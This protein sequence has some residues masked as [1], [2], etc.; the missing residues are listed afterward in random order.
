MNKQMGINQVKEK[1]DCTGYEISNLNCK[2][3]FSRSVSNYEESSLVAEEG[4][5][6]DPF[7]VTAQRKSLAVQT[8]EL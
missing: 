3:I 1:L 2:F 8:G 7:R 5:F 4:L 6:H